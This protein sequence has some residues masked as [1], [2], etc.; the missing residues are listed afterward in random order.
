MPPTIIV[1]ARTTDNIQAESKI[2]EMHDAIMLLE[3]DVAPLTL[4]TSMV[5]S[6]AV[7]QTEF[8]T[9]EDEHIPRIDRINNGAGYSN[10]ATSL[11]VDNGAYFAADTL[12]RVQR[13]GEVIRVD[14]VSTNTLDCTGGRGWG[15]TAA[16]AL[17]DNDQLTILSGAAKQ[18][19]VSGTS[20][21]T[22]KTIEKN[23]TQIVRWPFEL[24]GTDMAINV[25]GEDEHSYQRRKAFA[26]WKIRNEHNFLFGEKNEDTANS[27]RSTGGIDEFI[28]TN[29]Q[30]FGGGFSMTTFMGYASDLFRYGSKAKTAFISRGLASN[31][32]LEGR[33]LVE[34]SESEDSLGMVIKT[35]ITPH[36]KL[37]LITHD[38]LEGD[39]YGG[40][41]LVVDL[42]N[43]GYRYLNGRDVKLFT[44]VKSMQD[45]GFD[46]QMDEYLGEVGLW[47]TQEKTHGRIVN[48]A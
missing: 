42:N 26:E 21:T 43:V 7:G 48:G 35:L 1:G 37:S 45:G 15:S 20:R 38:L 34:K 31:I 25:Y 17:V 40:Y 32:A 6:K 19:E 24:T 9:Q 5:S 41:G 44:K 3:P 11:V 39:T 47:R 14:S 22:Q 10:S 36:G 29:S 30:N 33:S 12:F 46:G 23:F 28:A 16:Q 2:V 8:K 18:G 13:T 4:F 27:R